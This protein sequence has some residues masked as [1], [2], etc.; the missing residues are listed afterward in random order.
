[1]FNKRFKKRIDFLEKMTEIQRKQ[2][3]ALMENQKELKECIEG[4]YN[5]VK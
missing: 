1:M 2:I 5:V 3:T 4:L